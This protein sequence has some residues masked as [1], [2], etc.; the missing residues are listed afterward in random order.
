MMYTSAWVFIELGNA[1]CRH[2]L[3][4]WYVETLSRMRNEAS[5]AILPPTVEWFEE[6][7]ALFQSRADKEWSMTDCLSSVMMQRMGV[8]EALT[9]DRHFVQAGFRALLVED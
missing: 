1:L 2:P 4:G 5:T 7:A 9:A 6:G 8:R 3:R